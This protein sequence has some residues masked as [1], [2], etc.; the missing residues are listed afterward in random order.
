MDEKDNTR[1]RS[2]NAAPRELR[3]ADPSARRVVVF[4]FD[5]TIADSMPSIVATATRVL[6]DWGLPKERL[7]DVP[8]LVGPPFPQAFT[9]VFGLSDS[10]AR[11][12]TRRY[13]EAYEKIGAAAWPAFPG[14]AGLLDELRAAG[15]TLAVAS[16]KRTRLLRRGLTDQGLIGRFEFA[17]GKDSDAPQTK[18]QTLAKVLDTLGVGPD[19][20]VMVGDRFY[21]VDAAT[22]CGMPCVGVTYGHTAPRSELERAGACAVAQSVGELG[23]VLLGR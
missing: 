19:D 8:K 20:A 17:L 22:A 5:G 14:M 13:R 16:S 1:A 4:D 10:D 21:D 18:A 11:E 12:V 9:M 23:R 3:E 7:A 2:A 6:T 15:R